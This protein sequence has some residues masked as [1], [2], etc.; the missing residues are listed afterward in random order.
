ME[1]VGVRR[2]G[3]E[4]TSTRLV[5]AYYP[6][7]A[8][9]Y[10]DEW[11]G[12]TPRG[13]TPVRLANEYYKIT[14]GRLLHP[15]DHPAFGGEIRWGR[16]KDRRPWVEAT[17]LVGPSEWVFNGPSAEQDAEYA[18]VELQALRPDDRWESGPVD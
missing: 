7:M 5:Q 16:L 15:G 11:V 3:V 17:F 2:Y 12:F 1:T 8:G 10:Q 6:R 4:S 13:S 9:G 18:V 14:E